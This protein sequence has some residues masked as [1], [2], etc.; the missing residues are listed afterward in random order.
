MRNMKLV[1]LVLCAVLM[2]G[3]L[4]GCSSRTPATVKTFQMHMEAAG[5]TVEDVTAVT[6]TNGLADA[7]LVAVG[8]DYQIEFW[9][10]VGTNAG[11]TVF[12]ATR[13][14]LSAEHPAKFMEVE[15]TSNAYSYFAFNADGNFHVIARVEDTMLL[16]EAEKEHKDEIVDILKQLG[17]K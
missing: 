6:E 10:L 11:Q 17:Y 3:L 12:R 1:S 16:C 15:I 5:F 2:A 4:T 7:I 13:N 9:D 14:S 8:E